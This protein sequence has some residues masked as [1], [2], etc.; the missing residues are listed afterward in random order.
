MFFAVNEEPTLRSE[1][2][3]QQRQSHSTK[4]RMPAVQR[5]YP[6]RKGQVIRRLIRLEVKFL[7]GD[8]AEGQSSSL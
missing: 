5:A 2:G 6:Q 8:L 7:D 4:I 1:A 3:K